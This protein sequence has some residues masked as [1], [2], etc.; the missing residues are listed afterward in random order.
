MPAPTMKEQLEAARLRE[1]SLRVELIQSREAHLKTQQALWAIF[2]V[3]EALPDLLQV[4]SETEGKHDAA[5]VFIQK[6]EE[7]NY[8]AMI[9]LG[10]VVLGWVRSCADAKNR[11]EIIRTLDTL[12]DQL[13]GISLETTVRVQ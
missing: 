11:E 5:W 6:L 7:A 4:G 3:M 9:V 12:T 2:E 8:E 1:E 13:N 10:E